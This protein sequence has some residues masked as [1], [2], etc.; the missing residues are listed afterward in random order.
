MSV[1]CA[2]KLDRGAPF[3]VTQ[4]SNNYSTVKKRSMTGFLSAF[5][6]EN[7]QCQ[8]LRFH[9]RIFMISPGHFTYLLQKTLKIFNISQENSAPPMMTLEDDEPSN[10]HFRKNEDVYDDEQ[11]VQWEFTD[12]RVAEFTFELFFACRKPAP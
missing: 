1:G 9:V 2:C 12:I 5:T 10:I 3:E 6:I 11:Q 7:D 4:F 8:L